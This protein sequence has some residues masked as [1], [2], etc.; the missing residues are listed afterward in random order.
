MV[1]V[2]RKLKM[3]DIAKERQKTQFIIRFPVAVVG[4][5]E[6]AMTAAAL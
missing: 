1:T 5:V 6:L 4:L 2:N 3:K